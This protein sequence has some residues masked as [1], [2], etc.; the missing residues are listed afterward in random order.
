MLCAQDV[1]QTAI[2][3]KKKKATLNVQQKWIV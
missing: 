2:D 3:F 1:N